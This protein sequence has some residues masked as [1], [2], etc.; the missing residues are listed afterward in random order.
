M[1][2][3]PTH[4]EELFVCVELRKLLVILEHFLNWLKGPICIS[5]VNHL[6]AS[7]TFV[8]PTSRQMLQGYY[9]FFLPDSRLPRLWLGK[10]DAKHTVPHIQF[11][12]MGVRDL[13]KSLPLII[14]AVL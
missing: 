4:Y 6:K 12:N 2:T 13:F 8:K 5:L 11:L 1:L 3:V 7:K 14:F 9:S 10:K